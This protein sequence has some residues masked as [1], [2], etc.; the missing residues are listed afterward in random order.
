MT[1][2]VSL[3]LLRSLSAIGVAFALSAGAAVAAC[4]EAELD[5]SRQSALIDLIQKAP[6]AQSA[7]PHNAA[8][9][10]LWTEAPDSHAQDLLDSGMKRIRV[11]NLRGAIAALDALVEYC[12]DYA[13]GYNQRA[14]AHY[15]GQHY[16]Q[17]IEDL[18]VALALNSRHVGALSG[19]A[20]SLIGIGEYRQALTALEAALELN[21]HLSERS[22]LPKL[23]ER[24]GAEE[25]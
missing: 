1:L 18:D 19:K 22:L 21:P 7:R 12:P 8:L 4:P 15:L 9:W 5:A 23:E 25:L 17:A 20:L 24:L 13:E 2:Q 11:G 10:Q 3:H 14:F 6:D 16:A